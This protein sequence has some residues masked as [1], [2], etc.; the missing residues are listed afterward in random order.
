[1][2][3][4]CSDRVGEDAVAALASVL[5]DDRLAKTA[6]AIGACAVAEVRDDRVAK[7]A[8]AIVACT[9]DR[10]IRVLAAPLDPAGR[11]RGDVIEDRQVDLLGDRARSPHAAT[12]MAFRVACSEHSTAALARVQAPG[13]SEGEAR[14][15][16]PVVRAATRQSSSRSSRLPTIEVRVDRVAKTAVAVVASAHDRG[17][18]GSCGEDGCCGRRVC[19]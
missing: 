4:V 11:I 8:G 7:R 14:R 13:R 16:M 1:L 19:A 6:G 9:R 12:R 18:R 2:I 5:R 10:E 3:E 15:V 17:A